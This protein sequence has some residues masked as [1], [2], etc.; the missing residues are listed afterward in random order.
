MRL[1][2]VWNRDGVIVAATA[3]VSDD[4]SPHPVPA[5]GQDGGV[6]DVP[7]ELA[8]LPLDVLCQRVRVDRDTRTLRAD[9]TSA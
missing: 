8:D 1:D 7:G 3:L 5:E 2:A 9:N 6:L 4:P